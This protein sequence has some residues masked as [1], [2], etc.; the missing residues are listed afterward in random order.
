MLSVVVEV[1]VLV[2]VNVGVTVAVEV[3]VEVNV[4][5]LVGL[6]LWVVVGDDE[7]VR[8]V[9]SLV[10]FV[11]DGE[12]VSVLVPLVLSEVLRLEVSEVVADKVLVVLVVGVVLGG[13]A[14]EGSQLPHVTGQPL[15]S[16][17]AI[18]SALMRAHRLC[19]FRATQ[20]HDESFEVRTRVARHDGLSS[21]LSGVHHRPPP[22]MQQASFA[23][24]PVE[25]SRYIPPS[26]CSETPRTK[27]SFASQSHVQVPHD[28]TPLIQ[29]RKNLSEKK[30]HLNAPR[31]YVMGCYG[32]VRGKQ[33]VYFAVCFLIIVLSP[34]VPTATP[35]ISVAPLRQLIC[36]KEVFTLGG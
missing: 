17:A 15:L 9:V 2:I 18:P 5:V 31:P 21:H 33:G 3:D 25:M 13:Q 26:T 22:Q 1:G 35:S 30:K 29:P 23:T 19:G 27:R 8:V 36:C 34:A 6:E 16:H 28:T 32:A 4:V 14:L 12:D 24:S 11:L 10:L 7:V 20:L